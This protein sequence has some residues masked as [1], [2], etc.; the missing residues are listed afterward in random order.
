MKIW[1]L[2]SVFLIAS[3]SLGNGEVQQQPSK[4]APER[5]IDTKIK[6]NGVVNNKKQSDSHQN[7]SPTVPAAIPKDNNSIKDTQPSK[8][9]GTESFLLWGYRFKITDVLLVV[10][11]ALLWSSTR[12]LWKEA[13]TASSIAKKS[14]DAA[15][16]TAQNME[17][18]E[19]AYVKMSHTDPGLILKEGETTES[20][21]VEV[22]I[23]N[24][25]KTPA[26]VTEARLRF[27]AHDYDNPL[28]L[29]ID[30]T[31]SDAAERPSSAFLVPTDYFFIRR[32]SPMDKHGAI[33]NHQKR[34]I[35]F[36]YVDYTDIFGQQHRAGYAREY[37][38]VRGNNLFLIAA[39]GYNYDRPRRDTDRQDQDTIES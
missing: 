35:L 18:T 23:E 16:L 37:R 3:L 4:N 2:L 34:L 33:R 21:E 29:T 36:G 8:E 7:T 31:D 25:G 9:E 11:T 30:Y 6:T 26:M 5:E 32:G 14:A 27:M 10:F 12:K 24:C 1:R 39:K 22:K 20:Y 13:V 38:T 17:R 28:P 15:L 19:R